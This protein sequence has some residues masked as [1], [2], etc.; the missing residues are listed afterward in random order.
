MFLGP[1]IHAVV[2][3]C[4]DLSRVRWR[5]RLV[6]LVHRGGTSLDVVSDFAACGRGSVRSNSETCVVFYSGLV[7]RLGEC[8]WLAPARTRVKCFS[9]GAASCSGRIT[10]V[11]F[12]KIS[13][14]LLE[15]TCHGCVF[16]PHLA[17]AV[18]SGQ[19]LC[20]DH[21]DGPNLL[22]AWC[23]GS[24]RRLS[25]V[26]CCCRISFNPGSW[27]C[28][29]WCNSDASMSLSFETVTALLHFCVQMTRS[30]CAAVCRLL[31]PSSSVGRG[32]LHHQSLLLAVLHRR[33]R[34]SWR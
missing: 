18:I 7:G 28:G 19:C 17:R 26:P 33:G 1:S 8:G 32:L 30:A 15:V 25:P 23:S 20:L 11:H 16:E 2:V 6:C 34:L 10:G 21:C 27:K 31:P 4:V 3:V 9:A 5:S 13:Q 22:T 14:R 12:S 29:V 24:V